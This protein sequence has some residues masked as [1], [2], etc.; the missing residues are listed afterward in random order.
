MSWLVAKFPRFK[1][2]EWLSSWKQLRREIEIDLSETET[3]FLKNESRLTHCFP[4]FMVKAILHL[5]PQCIAFW[6]SLM[7]IHK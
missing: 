5:G 1:Y 6:Q 7:L 4:L 3:A 2:V